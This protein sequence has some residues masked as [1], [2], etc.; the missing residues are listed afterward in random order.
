MSDILEGIINIIKS[1]FIVLGRKIEKAF[2][3]R[4]HPPKNDHTHH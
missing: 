2:P 3:K 1:A 4:P